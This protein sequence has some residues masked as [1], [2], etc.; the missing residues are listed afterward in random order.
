MIKAIV[1]DD[2]ELQEVKEFVNE[3]EL[4]VFKD[5][6]ET[7]INMLGGGSGNEGV[8]CY[9]DLHELE[10]ERD[11]ADYAQERRYAAKVIEL[12]NRHLRE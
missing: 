4:T 6:F 1:V 3:A 7:G 5:G 8:Y 9:A 12:I 2:G 11:R 10:Q